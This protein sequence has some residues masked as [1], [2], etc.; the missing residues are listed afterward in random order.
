M[1]I[2]KEAMPCNDQW[3][4]DSG[5]STHMMGRKYWI[6][7]INHVVKNKVKLADKTI[8]AAKDTDDVS[9]ERR[10]DTS[11][12]IKNVL[13]ILGIKGYHST[14]GYKLYDTENRMIVISQDVIFNK[15]K[16]LQQPVTSKLVTGYNSEKS[17]YVK[18]E[19]AEL[20]L[21]E[22]RIDKKVRRSARQRGLPQR[23]T[24]LRWEL[25]DIPE[26]K[27]QRHMLENFKKFEVEHCNAAVTSAEPMLQLSKN[28]DEQDVN[29]TQ[30]RRLI[31]SLRYSCNT[32][33]DFVSRFIE[34]S[35]VSHLAAVKR[36]LRYVK[37]SI[38][39]GI[40]FPAMD[41]CRKCNVFDFTNSNW[42]G[43]KDVRKSTVGYIFMFS[44]TPISWCLKKKPVITLFTCEDE[45]IT[46]SLCV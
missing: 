5:C 28:E 21:V 37:G 18:L 29:P 8:I 41:T 22:A 10:D 32:R 39:C 13:Y 16:Q 44:E 45:Y 4:L 19:S 35:K 3:Y 38:S 7:T 46:V 27:K 31:G 15:I 42:C 40:L 14:S 9:I 11:S 25:V 1:V 17:I 36:I 24:K 30:Y 12:L 23:L 6:V 34:R 43:D 20:A 33:L 2:F 26:G